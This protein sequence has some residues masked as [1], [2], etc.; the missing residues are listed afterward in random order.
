MDLEVG[1]KHERKDLVVGE[2]GGV[3]VSGSGSEI[4]IKEELSEALSSKE[5]GLVEGSFE[6]LK[7]VMCSYLFVDMHHDLLTT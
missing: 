4:M 5:E 7:I 2:E 6:F 1:E 3:I